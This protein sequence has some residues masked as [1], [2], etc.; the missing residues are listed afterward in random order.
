ML[1][2]LP[3]NLL[4]IRGWGLCA[5]G[6]VSLIAAEVLGRRDLLHLGFFL[7][8]LPVLAALALQLLKPRFIIERA[9]RPASIETGSTTTA[10]LG[11]RRSG[12]LGGS[13]TMTEQLPE[14][15]GQ[16]P[17]FTYPSSVAS[18]SGRS[19]YEYRLRTDR[20]GLYRIGPVSADFA[21]PFGLSHHHHMLG[22]VD[23]LTVTPAP[24]P[25]PESSV[26]GSRGTEGATATRTQANPSNDDVMT[27]EYR[28]G[29]P[30][31]RVHWPATARQGELM[32]RQEESVT[33]PQATI[34]MDQR[35]T[36]FRSNAYTSLA[37]STPSKDDL[38]TT[39]N[40]EWAVT[41]VVSAAHH[42]M[43]RNYSVRLLDS[44]AA[45]GLLRS[46][47]TSWPEQEE[48]SGTA[49]MHN[50]AEGLAD[51]QLEADPPSGKTT[52]RAPS[53]TAH[54]QRT[55]APA[56]PAGG[57]AFSD[58]LMEALAANRLR[59]PLIAVT[60]R[61]TS[62]EAAELAAAAEF[63]SHAFA[64]L[65]TDRPGEA[66]PELDILRASGWR[67]VAVNSKSSLPAAWAHYDAPHAHSRPTAKTS[68]G[69]P[70]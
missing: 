27:R 51:L 1:D 8:L 30:M 34:I 13:I 12:P 42:L 59:G 54:P 38:F 2:K 23:M 46:A 18:R 21:D 70:Q 10:R 56:G 67:A 49:G 47:S 24:H 32:V 7:I 17:A 19:L 39:V 29:D 3:S 62:A 36:A 6:A 55:P 68:L 52:N 48:F 22:D 25:L 11:V 66:E 61:L 50:L 9:F 37:E 35:A 63:G 69:A 31:R 5:A 65:V 28:H 43:E 53:A 58:A 41:A 64:L 16:P 4:T 20:R 44:R 40:F 57:G 33:T 26:S 14:H 45:A 60:G 15:F